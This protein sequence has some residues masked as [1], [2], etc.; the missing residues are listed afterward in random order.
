M[1][2]P[3]EFHPCLTNER[4]DYVGRLISRVRAENLEAAATRDNGW[5]LGCRAHAWVC[6]EIQ[7]QAESIEWLNIVDPS[8][9]FIGKIGNVEF[10]FYKGPANKPKK[11][12]CSRAQSHPELRQKSLPF[13]TPLPSK[14]VWT[15]AIETDSEGLTTN[16][17]FFGMSE[18]GQ[19]VA[20]RI[21]PIFS[22]ILNVVP[23]NNQHS[24]PADLPPAPVSL[25]TNKKFKKIDV[26][27]Q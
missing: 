5:S 22:E 13:T 8:L 7:N 1:K 12:I 6:N 18:S 4:I 23:I 26:A 16:V 2:T 11:N 19:I 27:E 15:Y 17:E 24:E 20:S 10:S 9:R 25:P 3:Y 21:V 14:L